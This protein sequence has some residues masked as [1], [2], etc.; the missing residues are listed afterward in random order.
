MI[1][2]YK[3]TDGF[4]DIILDYTLNEGYLEIGDNIPEC[5]IRKEQELILVEEKI[6]KVQ[7]CKQYLDDTEHK[8]NMDY[9]PKV[10]E[11]LELIRAKRSEAR[12]FV[13]ANEEDK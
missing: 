1:K 6:N 3:E 10:G 8:F 7:Q 5:V 9:E 13:R 4:V 2:Q 12:A 11:D